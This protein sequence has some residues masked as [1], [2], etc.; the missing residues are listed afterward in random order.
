MI[1][2]STPEVSVITAC[3]N[4]EK[5]IAETIKSVQNQT[6]SNWEYIIADNGSNDDTVNIIKDFLFDERIKLVIEKRRGKTFA[7]NA[8]FKLTHG[9]YIAN[10]DADDQW[11]PTKL[12]EQVSILD[13]NYSIPLVYTGFEIIDSNG[14]KKKNIIP[15]DISKDPMK[16]LLTF[17]N[18]IV[19]SS[20]IIRKE[21]FDKN[22]YQD[23]EIEKVDEQIVYLKTFLKSNR[24]ALIKIPLT[25][26]RVHE[27]SEFSLIKVEEFK[28][29]YEK[30]FNTFFGLFDLP[31]EIMK[32][33]KQAY[34]T[35]YYLSAST[36]I[37]LAKDLNLS[38]FYLLKSVW[39]RP[40]KIH[41][42]T[43]QFL[44]LLIK[45]INYKS[46]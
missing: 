2:I 6:F 28:Y 32:L 16:Y 22:E 12:E 46:H 15:Q 20:V 17:K 43:Y 21:V 11:N 36:G 40:N 39:L 8:A 26:Y 35:M 33:K 18:P 45:W 7:R 1:N 13:S 42:C 30:G 34:G 3:Y 31:Q 4:A 27:D 25:K 10:I 5:Y 37:H 9:K 29:W 41:Y 14:I 19:H 44:K 24:A 23:E 38:F